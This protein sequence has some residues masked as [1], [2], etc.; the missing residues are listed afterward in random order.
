MRLAAAHAARRKQFQAGSDVED[1]QSDKENPAEKQVAVLQKGKEAQR[2][3][4]TYW[5]KKTDELRSELKEKE[6]DDKAKEEEMRVVLEEKD[7]HIQELQREL[8]EEK[9]NERWMPTC[10]MNRRTVWREHYATISSSFT[11]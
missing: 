3:K 11:R 9:A 2:K 1:S 8:Q 4:I 6:V 7:Q 10:T 5:K